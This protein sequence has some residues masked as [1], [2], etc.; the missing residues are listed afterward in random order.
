MGKTDRLNR[1]Q[2]SGQL[3]GNME[4][5]RINEGFKRK[6]KGRENKT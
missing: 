1:K 2:V 5:K 6:T 4:V 3:Q